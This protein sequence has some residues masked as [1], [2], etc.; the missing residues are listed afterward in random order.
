MHRFFLAIGS[1]YGFL[2]VALGA[3]AAHAL[4]GR[5]EPRALEILETGVRYQMIHA[6]VLVCVALLIMRDPSPWFV[7]AGWAFAFGAL[8]FPVSLQ[9]L[10][11]TGMSRLGAVAPIGGVALLIGWICLGLGAWKTFAGP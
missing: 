3:F 4:R 10:A 2:S 11:L 9:V 5:L 7:R 6:V 8:I 1:L